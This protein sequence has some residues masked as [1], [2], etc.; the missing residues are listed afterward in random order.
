MKW[1]KVVLYLAASVMFG[2]ALD[3]GFWQHGA[4]MGGVLCLVWAEE[5]GT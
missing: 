2:Y 4:L 1:Q 5:G 3:L